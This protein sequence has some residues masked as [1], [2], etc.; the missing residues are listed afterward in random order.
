MTLFALRNLYFYWEDRQQ[1]KE[2]KFFF[3][4]Y[5]VST[6]LLDTHLI[7]EAESKEQNLNNGNPQLVL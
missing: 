1:T 4:T 5:I 7:L 2:K 3:N 6:S